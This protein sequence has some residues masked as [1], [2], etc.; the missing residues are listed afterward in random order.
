[1]AD[2]VPL[3]VIYHK[4]D[5]LIKVIADNGRCILTVYVFTYRTEIIFRKFQKI[6]NRLRHRSYVTILC[7]NEIFLPIFFLTG[8]KILEL[9]TISVTTSGKILDPIVDDIINTAVGSTEQSV[10]ICIDK[11]HKSSW[12]FIC[13]LSLQVEHK[14]SITCLNTLIPSAHQRHKRCRI[15]GISCKCLIKCSLY[16]RGISRYPCRKGNNTGRQPITWRCKE[17]F[18]CD[19]VDCFCFHE[20][21]WRRLKNTKHIISDLFIF[22]KHLRIILVDSDDFGNGALQCRELLLLFSELRNVALKLC[23]TLAVHLDLF[24]SDYDLT[25]CHQNVRVSQDNI[26]INRCNLFRKLI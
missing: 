9:C 14:P 8:F 6:G 26:W 20:I 7:R 1:M 22:A 10:D 18:F 23:D 4:I 24:L 12:D 16:E 15:V 2:F 21:L 13:G 3:F 17:K 25:L 5:N 19:A 11:Q